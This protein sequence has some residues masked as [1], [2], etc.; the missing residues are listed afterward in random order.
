MSSHARERVS[1]GVPRRTQ[2]KPLGLNAAEIIAILVTA[3]FFV[4]ALY[5]YFTTLGPE[6][7]RLQNFETQLGALETEL[8]KARAEIDQPPAIDTT[9]EALDSLAAFKQKH[10]RTITQGEIALYRDINALAAKHQ[11]QITSSIEMKRENQQEDSEKNQTKK[12]ATKSK[13]DPLSVVYPQT[14][15]NFSVAGQYANLRA[16]LNELER[17]NQFIIIRSVALTKSEQLE[18]GGSRRRRGSEGGAIT[19]AIEMSAYFHP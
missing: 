15:I 10:L 13:T 8:I 19:L 16:F 1:I 18:E 7:R 3:A 6:Q 9:R 11:T 2:R 4:A 12:K 5:Y 14:S 17:N